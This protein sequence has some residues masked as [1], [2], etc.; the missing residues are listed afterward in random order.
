MCERPYG[1][2][3]YCTVDPEGYGADRKV[4]LP[5]PGG[6]NE[7]IGGLR[8]D[9][10]FVSNEQSLTGR[11]AGVEMM[12]QSM[13]TQRTEGVSDGAGSGMAWSSSSNRA[14]ARQL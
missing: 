10:R 3:R 2:R 7:V 13:T 14:G 9:R 6:C 11:S 8:G 5:D 1:S 12:R 4:S